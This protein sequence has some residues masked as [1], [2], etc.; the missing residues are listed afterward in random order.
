[1]FK[2]TTNMS[3]IYRLVFILSG[4]FCF[5]NSFAFN[6]N[7]AQKTA[8]N[9]EGLI[10]Q[11]YQLG[12]QQN[13]GQVKDLRGNAAP[14]VLFKADAP[15]V[16]I[17]VTTSGLTYQFTKFEEKHE[18]EEDHEKEKNETIFAEWQRV[19]MI[20]K[21]A[22]IKQENIITE[23]DITKGEINY[24]LAHCQNGVLGVKT[25]TK[26]TIKNIYEGID[27]VLYA[28]ENADGDFLKQDFVVHPNAN[29]NQIKLIYTGIGDFSIDNNQI[30]F[31]NNLGEVN[32]GKLLCYQ[33]SINNIVVSNYIIKE[34]NKKGE[35]F[36]YELEVNVGDYNKTETLVIDPKLTWATF[37]GG[38]NHDGTLAIQTDDNGNIFIA[39]YS[40]STN[41]PVYH[42]GGTAYQGKDSAD[43]DAA[44]FKFDNIGKPVWVTYYGGNKP[45]RSYSMC[46]DA[47]GNMFATGFAESTD[48]PLLNLSG[49]FN[50]TTN[51][52]SDDA[53]IIKFSNTGQRLW[54]TYYGGG[55]SD[56]ANSISCDRNNNIFLTGTTSSST[57]PVQSLS[58]AYNQSSKGGGTDAFILKFTNSG[59]RLWATYYGGVLDEFGF[60]ICNDSNGNVFATGSSESSSFPVLS[61]SGAFNQGSNKGSEDA[62]VLKFTNN[63]QRLWATYY[64]G[65]SDDIGY[66]IYCDKNDNVYVL[67]KTNSTSSSFP[68][69]NSGS[70]AYYQAANGGLSD[71]F[72]IKFA[73]NGQRIWS[74]FYG[75]SAEETFD[76]Y[77]NIVEDACG[78]IYMAFNTKSTNMPTYNLPCTD[79]YKKT[80]NN[81]KNDIFII[82]FNSSG[83]RLWSTYFGGDGEDFRSAVAVDKNNNFLIT[84]EWS[85]VT[86]NA[87][88]PATDPGG[89][90]YFDASH[91]T[92]DD[93]YIAKFIY[94]APSITKSQ[95][96]ATGC[97]GNCNGSA[98]INLNCAE[99]NYNY[100]W[101]N[102]SQTLNS[103]NS[104]NS[105]SGLCPGTYTVTITVGC[106]Q[107]SVTSTF[108]ITSGS[109]GSLPNITAGNNLTLGCTKTSGTISASSSTPGV[110]YQWSGPGIISGGTT[111][112]P[113]VN[114]AGTYTVIVTNPITSCT[115]ST[116]VTVINNSTPPVITTGNPLE[117]NCTTNSGTISVTSS[118]PNCTY[119]WAGIGIVSGNTTS[120]PTVNQTGTYTVTV[121]NPANGC[122]NTSTITV[123]SNTT[124]PNINVSGSFSITCITTSGSLNASSTT[125]GATYLWT[126]PGIVSGNTSTSPNVNVAGTYTVTVTN[127]INGCTNSSTITVNSNTTPPNINAISN[128]VLNC[129]TNNATLSASSS[130]SNINYLWNG[131][132]I[133]SGNTSAN[134]LI[135]TP[136]SY[137]VTI[138][139]LVNG[140]TSSSTVN[141]ITGVAPTAI[142]SADISIEE[143]DST[144]LISSGGT[145]YNWFPST[146][147]SCSNCSS[148]IAA[149]TESTT[150]CVAV[151]DTNDC[152]DTACVR[153][154]VSDLCPNID[155][156]LVL[157]NIF[158]TNIDGKNDFFFIKVIPIN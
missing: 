103:S 151:S 36:L 148:P 156:S 73:N 150:Y 37:Y 1:M 57:F 127:P 12:F 142:V 137:T 117:L 108:T 32:E 143:G 52:G 5:F 128:A 89:N 33:K 121:T 85:E 20:L 24:F 70:G 28:N 101:S 78:N 155:T 102:G 19:D 122:T 98:T 147:L 110:T 18:K 90:T 104:T 51:N 82:K 88:Y 86:S 25:F 76:S 45:D 13:K 113:T 14:N 80:T 135:N 124:L 105:V 61:L 31:K 41:F 92:N 154:E 38:S 62:Y 50:Q 107:N 56:I 123:T 23:G 17:W 83:I 144:Q 72:I 145:N 132:G 3:L 146:G 2:T 138:T 96:N 58:G 22:S 6:A 109:G 140:C 67:G 63:G 15:G 29:P 9:A 157:P 120:S 60:S 79:D 94:V 112:S 65:Y 48:F 54:A 49:A 84:G 125:S 134:P 91:N 131:P 100:V 69:L 130:T 81:G 119:S 27:W 158:S 99:P 153:I 40:F 74:T 16:T 47:N 43:V 87:T 149:P 95:V 10:S 64:G 7:L 46:L 21:N 133:V 44:F 106:L 11:N 136:G 77:D 59:Q 111:T 4:I 141:V 97:N 30:N 75:G 129:K 152:R 42:P 93:I 126:G 34:D 139:D 53:F 26:I 114:Q 55:V 35:Q 71:A 66:T 68:L 39:G 116:T 118:A 8:T 115:N